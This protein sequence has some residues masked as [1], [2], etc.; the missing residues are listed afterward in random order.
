VTASPLYRERRN[1]LAAW[2]RDRYGPNDPDVPDAAF[3]R[4]AADL[5]KFLRG[6][7]LAIIPLEEC[8]Q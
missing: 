8:T 3:W 4:D 6:N 2:L 5:L 1:A 7:G